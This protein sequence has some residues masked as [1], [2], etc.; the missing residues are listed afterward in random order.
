MN[1]RADKRRGVTLGRVLAGVAVAAAAGAAWYYA[2]ERMTEAPDH[3]P[4]ISDGVFALRRYPALI[5]A[6]VVRE[7]QREAALKAGFGALA[8]Y[9]FAESRAGE[10]IAMT[11][12][13]LLDRAG[14]GWRTRFIMP[15][16]W[17][18][19]TLP[20]P[21]EGVAIEDIA[22][23]RVATIRFSGPADD[24]LIDRKADALRAWMALQGLTAASHA[25]FAFYNSPAIPGPLRR[26]EVWM[27]VA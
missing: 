21:G 27:Q 23:R 12:P 26:N 7:G 22:P 25:E 18:H 3:E 8:D 13:V 24:A 19:G 9:I 6:A 1:E 4:I 14:Q 5:A 16:A 11:V 17:T 15:A 20:A 2:R 10:P